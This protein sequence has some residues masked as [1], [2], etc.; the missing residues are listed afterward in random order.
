MAVDF[1]AGDKHLVV[2]LSDADRKRIVDFARDKGF[3]LP[4]AYAEVIKVGMERLE[5]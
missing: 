1:V 5:I 4:R 2:K 3:T